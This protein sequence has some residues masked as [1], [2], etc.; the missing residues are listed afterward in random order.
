VTI[1]FGRVIENS[2]YFLKM[3]S[4][5]CKHWSFETALSHLVIYYK[6]MGGQ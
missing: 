2:I 4:L 6:A 1:S 3:F 5:V